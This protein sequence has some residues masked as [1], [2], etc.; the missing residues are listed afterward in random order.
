MNTPGKKIEDR[1]DLLS[2]LP[3]EESGI[4]SKQIL[5]DDNGS[6]T[7]FS[8]FEGEKLSCNSF[9]HRVLLVG[10]EGIAELALDKERIT[11]GALVSMV[12]PKDTKYSLVATDNFKM[13][14]ISR[15]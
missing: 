13:L 9:P 10:L 7:V 14:V 6:A 5:K 2:L 1:L 3:Y 11:I 4:V 12:I 15:I 8:I